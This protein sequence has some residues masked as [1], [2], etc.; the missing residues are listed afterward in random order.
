VLAVVPAVVVASL[1]GLTFAACGSDGGGSMGSPGTSSTSAAATG[2]PVA[3]DDAA[4]G[5]TVTLPRGARLTVTLHSTYWQLAAPA[6]AR[7]LAVS[8]VPAARPDPSCRSIP[9]AGCGTVTAVYTATG[10][11]TTTL[12]AHRDSC[13]EALRCTPAQSDWSLRIRVRG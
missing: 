12:T 7:V 2:K 5:T 1:A 10:T 8:T 11:G 13:G 6:D 4:N 9:G 3:V